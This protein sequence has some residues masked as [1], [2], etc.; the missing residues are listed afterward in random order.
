[1]KPVLLSFLYRGGGGARRTRALLERVLELGEQ[2]LRKKDKPCCHSW[3]SSLCSVSTSCFWRPAGG[4]RSPEGPKSSW[5]HRLLEAQ[6]PNP[7]PPCTFRLSHPFWVKESPLPQ[8][9]PRPQ[10]QESP[11]PF[12]QRALSGSRKYLTF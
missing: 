6:F 8:G 1:M 12:L 11:N 2:K 4:K 5:W 7:A 3:P 10:A 9:A